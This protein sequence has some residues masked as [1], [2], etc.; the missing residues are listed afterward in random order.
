V[1]PSQNERDPVP[2]EDFDVI[3]RTTG[4]HPKR[5]GTGAACLSHLAG[6]RITFRQTTSTERARIR[7]AEAPC[8]AR[9]LVQ[10]T[11]DRRADTV[12][13]SNILPRRLRG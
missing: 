3:K 5:L 10:R 7:R 9:Q 2:G 11:V 6:V 4:E 13:E 12:L 1:G 8:G